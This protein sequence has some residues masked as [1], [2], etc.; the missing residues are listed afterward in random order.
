MEHYAGVSLTRVAALS[1]RGRVAGDPKDWFQALVDEVEELD[2]GH[3]LAL[4]SDGTDSEDRPLLPSETKSAVARL[5]KAYKGLA[6]KAREVAASSGDL[7]QT[8]LAV[9]LLKVA[10]ILGAASGKQHFI[11]A[12]VGNAWGVLREFAE[13][14]ESAGY[15]NNIG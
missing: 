1:R 8:K 5:V 3:V 7:S 2:N 10:R 13:E 9:L 11:H 4:L 12:K 15:S 14:A 6:D